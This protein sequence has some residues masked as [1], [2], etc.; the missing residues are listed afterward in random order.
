MIGLESIFVLEHPD[1]R[2]TLVREKH[3]KM[4]EAPAGPNKAGGP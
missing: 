3:I 2:R 4:I 1:G